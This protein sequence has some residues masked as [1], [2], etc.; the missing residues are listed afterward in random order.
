[1][2]GV[3]L[4]QHCFQCRCSDKEKGREEGR[5]VVEGMKKEI[6]RFSF[7]LA[8]F[9]FQMPYS[10]IISFFSIFTFIPYCFFFFIGLVQV[11]GQYSERRD[12]VRASCRLLVNISHF[13]GVVIALEKMG[14]LEKLLDCV[15]MHKEARDVVESTALLMRGTYVHACDVVCGVVVVAEVMLWVP[16]SNCF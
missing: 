1:M 7:L 13:P 10:S 4:C 3:I 8:L 12:V 9:T 14:I 11:I 15:Y 5:K 16:Q 6:I 2:S